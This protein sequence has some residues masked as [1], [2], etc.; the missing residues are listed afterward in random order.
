M[1]S[2]VKLSLL[3]PDYIKIDVDGAEQSI[4]LGMSETVKNK[5]LKSVV[6]EVSETSELPITKFFEEA[7]FKIDFERRWPE[8]EIN[9]KNIIFTRK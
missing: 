7:G 9:F 4:I 3:N 1:D 5:R 6:I 8:A 2:F